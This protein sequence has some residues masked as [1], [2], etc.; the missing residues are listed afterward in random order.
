L[1]E[2]LEYT[3]LNVKFCFDTGHAHMKLGLHPS[4]ETLRT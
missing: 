3:R 1:V 2:F 4:F